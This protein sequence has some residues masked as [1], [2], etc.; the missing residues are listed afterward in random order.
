MTFKLI[1]D[2]NDVLVEENS[3]L[4]IQREIC[5]LYIKVS[6]YRYILKS[7]FTKKLN[8]TSCVFKYKPTTNKARN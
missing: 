7:Y 6:V 4:M 1:T 2:F 5:V 3:Y 8:L